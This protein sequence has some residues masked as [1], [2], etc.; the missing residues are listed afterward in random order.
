[1]LLKPLLLTV[2]SSWTE[3]GYQFKMILFWASDGYIGLLKFS[4]LWRP[5]PLLT[6]QDIPHHPDLQMILERDPLVLREFL[7]C[8][9]WSL[10]NDPMGQF[11][12]N[13]PSSL[14]WSWPLLAKKLDWRRMISYSY[15]SPSCPP[16]PPPSYTEAQ[17]EGGVTVKVNLLIIYQLFPSQKFFSSKCDFFFD[18]H[19][20][21]PWCSA[22]GE[23]E[24]LQWVMIIAVCKLKMQIINRHIFSL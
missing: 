16:H 10:K 6:L 9:L 18:I 3:A 23:F 22:A 14:T 24:S 17:S 21:P 12:H 19:N 5:A 1:M 4:Y 8:A 7:R 2:V 15:T 11:S 13:P 20:F